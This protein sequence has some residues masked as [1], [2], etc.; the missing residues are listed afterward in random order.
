MES[1]Y[2]SWFARRRG[3]GSK[4]IVRATPA[5]AAAWPASIIPR[6]ALG[7]H[8]D[9]FGKRADLLLADRSPTGYGNSTLKD[10]PMRQRIE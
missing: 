1:D 2:A 9:V 4:N 5:G 6:P 7:R 8:L 10:P 3:Y